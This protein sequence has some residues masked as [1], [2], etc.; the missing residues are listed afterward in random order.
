MLHF[1]RIEIDGHF[2]GGEPVK[3]WCA[4]I[5]G[6]SLKYG[7]E[8]EFIRPKNDW[9]DASASMRGR[10]YGVVST[11]MVREGHLYEVQRTRGKPSKRRVVREFL[12]IEGGKERVV[13]A[14]EALAIA[15]GD[16]RDGVTLFLREDRS[17]PAS[18]SRVVGLGTPT[19]KAYVV[20]GDLRRYR[21]HDGDLYEV[22]GVDM[23]GRSLGP[24]LGVRDGDT[25]QLTE[26]EAIEWLLRRNAA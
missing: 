20:E 9:A 24:F 10:V 12:W 1:I 6:P 8:R 14:D 17:A 26:Q 2:H 18:L 3:P 16:T 22:R 23:Q 11:F 5:L 13:S 25:I 4:R 19:P 21:L 15:D 7:L